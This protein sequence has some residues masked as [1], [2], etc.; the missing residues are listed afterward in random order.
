MRSWL[1]QMAHSNVVTTGLLLVAALVALC[2]ANG[3]MAALFLGFWSTPLSPTGFFA[4][5]SLQHLVNDGLMA[6][7][8]LLIGCEIKKEMHDGGLLSPLRKAGL[9]LFAA[10]GGILFPACIYIAFAHGTAFVSGWA[11]PTATDI[12]FVL[13]IVTALS[14][15]VPRWIKVFLMVLAVAD[16]LGAVLIL[17]VFYSQ[18]FS[19]WACAVALLLVGV[20]VIF[21]MT[22][23]HRLLVYLVVG[24]LLWVAFAYAGIHPTLAGVV[25]GLALSA[26][27]SANVSISPVQKMEAYIQPFVSLLVL[28]LFVLANAG[29]SLHSQLFSFRPLIFGVFFGLLVGKPMGIALFSWILFR[30]KFVQKPLSF[31]WLS[32]IGASFLAGIGFTMSLFVTQVSFVDAQVK[33]AAKISIFLGSVVSAAI[34]TGLIV[35]ASKK[36]ARPAS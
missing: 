9:P 20:L 32:F 11:I 17:A 36:Q 25:V 18:G 29:I 1:K 19:L 24:V 5:C 28:P 21:S 27:P 4:H 13:G 23:Q 8:F 33:A 15:R 35:L 16:D 7:F 26:R 3:P 10:C 6:F 34:G 14:S 31:R 12:A 30:C 2:M 22:R